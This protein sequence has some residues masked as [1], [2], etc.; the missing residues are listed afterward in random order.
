MAIVNRINTEVDAI[1]LEKT[2]FGYS[3]VVRCINIVLHARK[4][5]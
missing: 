5:F 3:C 4:C 1:E 2:S